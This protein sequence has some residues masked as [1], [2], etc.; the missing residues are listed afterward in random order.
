MSTQNALC[1]GTACGSES[2]LA[3]AVDLC[4][5]EHGTRCFSESALLAVVIA[6]SCFPLVF[7]VLSEPVRIY[8]AC[9]L[10][11]RSLLLLFLLLLLL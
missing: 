9:L 2:R 5:L 1:N 4:A 3:C 6:N 7:T 8:S 11:R 10:M